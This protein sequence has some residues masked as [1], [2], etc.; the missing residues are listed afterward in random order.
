MNAGY[1]APVGSFPP[2][3]SAPPFWFDGVIAVP[4][5]C[6]HDMHAMAE[7]AKFANDLCHDVTRRCCIW[8]EVWTNDCDMHVNENLWIEQFAV[9]SEL[10]GGGVLTRKVTSSSKARV[11]Q[12]GSVFRVKH[13]LYGVAP[14]VNV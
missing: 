9:N 7:S 14:R 6:R 8:G 4:G 13:L 11:D 3:P 2:Y 1:S 10:G 12:F 5:Q